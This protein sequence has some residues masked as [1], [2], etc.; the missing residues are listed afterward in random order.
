MQ[1]SLSHLSD[2]A[3]LDRLNKLAAQDRRTTAA[4]VECIVETWSRRLHRERGYSSMYTYCVGALQMSADVA[5][6]RIRVARIA[7]R[8]PRVLDAIGDGRMNITGLVILSAYLT[9]ENGDEL[10][11]LCE[12]RS[13]RDI[14]M[15][16]AERFPQPDV[17]TVL[18]PLPP[19]PAFRQ[20][21]AQPVVSPTNS[22]DTATTAAASGDDSPVIQPTIHS[23]A[24]LTPL[25]PQRFELQTTIG[26][27]LE[28]LLREAHEL[29]GHPTSTSHVPE[30]LEE[31]ME[32]FV[33]KLRKQKFG[34]TDSP[35]PA[36]EPNPESRHI[37]EDVKRAVWDRDGG[38]CAFMSED[39][40]RCQERSNL[41]YDHIVPFSR[42]GT[43]TVSNIR[44]LCWAHNQLEAERTFGAEFMD[45]KR[46]AS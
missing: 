4:L 23:T 18:K 12:K 8:F 39:G 19:S 46:K 34:A 38:Q 28:A 44:L 3:L 20:L 25:A 9:Q 33:E 24:I 5:Y 37:P 1:T 17:P 2:A 11:T 13:N 40:H 15:L 7:A 36:R 30:V 10:L 43:A 16:L 27:R 14:R 32:N 35:R 31:A 6:K 26:Q 41:E 21:A 42:G 22:P 45:Q 29:L